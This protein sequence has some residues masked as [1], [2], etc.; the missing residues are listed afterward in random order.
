MV[1]PEVGHEWLG[2]G[3]RVSPKSKVQ[4]PK[5][6]AGEAEGAAGTWGVRGSGRIGPG[7]TEL[8]DAGSA[9]D[10]GLRMR[11]ARPHWLE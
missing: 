4:S 5:S 6:G 8:S 9:G 10:A 1:C 11:S 3:Q 7:R 2:S